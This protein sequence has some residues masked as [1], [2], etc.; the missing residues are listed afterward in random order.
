VVGLIFRIVLAVG[1]AVTI[2]VIG[3]AIIRK[4][5]IEAPAEPDP[6]DLVP[7]DLRYRCGV[8]GAEV[9]MTA[10]PDE[11]PTPPRHCREDMDLVSQAAP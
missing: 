10:A 2:Y 8:C 4:F 11:E 5:H 9:T 1:A 7:V 6:E 3:A